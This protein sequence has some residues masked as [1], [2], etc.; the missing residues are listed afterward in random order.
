MK[1]ETIKQLLDNGMTSAELEKALRH[2]SDLRCRFN[3]IAT[4]REKIEEKYKAD[5][6]ELSHRLKKIRDECPHHEVT[7][8]PDPSG[9]NDSS[10]D[11]D[12]CGKSARRRK[13]LES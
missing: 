13:G 6:E 2:D 5:L 11:C 8:H 9:N 10:Y 3:L 12:L 1:P 4:D 7:Y